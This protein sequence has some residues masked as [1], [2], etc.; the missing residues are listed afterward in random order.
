MFH[1]QITHRYIDNDNE[2]SSYDVTILGPVVNH[3][4]T[5]ETIEQATEFVK[6]HLRDYL[7]ETGQ[8]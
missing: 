7:I 6:M 4:G 1:I 2:E 5:C 3:R 8:Y